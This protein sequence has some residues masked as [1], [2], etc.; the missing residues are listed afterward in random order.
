MTHM[1]IQTYIHTHML[2]FINIFKASPAWTDGDVMV[3]YSA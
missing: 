1:Y 3:S 2:V